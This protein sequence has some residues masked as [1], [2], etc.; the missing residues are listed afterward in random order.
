MSAFMRWAA[1]WP[2]LLVI[3]YTL[4]G[5]ALGLWL[6]TRPEIPLNIAGVLLT[7][8]TLVYSGYLIHECVHQT[9]F[10]RAGPNDLLGMLMSWL[11]GSCLADYQRLKIKHLRHHT[12]R[13]DV[14]T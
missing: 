3:S 1:A 2:N 12:D 11:N 6:L 8:H 5:W 13:L 9:I 4:I 10:L 14:V 7:S